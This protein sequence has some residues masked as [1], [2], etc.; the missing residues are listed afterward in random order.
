MQFRSDIQGLRALA[1]LLVFIFHLNKNWLPGGFLGVDLFFVI[2]GFLMTTITLNE[3]DLGK[4]SFLK[5]YEKRI[6]RILP[7][8]LGFLTI[9]SLVGGG[10]YIYTDIQGFR[11]SILKA[12]K[13]ISNNHFANGE[14]YFGAKLSENPVLH[15]WSLS[16][17][18]QFYFILPFILYF[19]RKYLVP[20]FI[21]SILGISIYSTYDIYFLENQQSSYFSL[22]SRIPEF[23]IGCLYAI[24]FKDGLDLSR[25][26]NDI[27]ASTSLLILLLCAIFYT[28][29]TPFP[30]ILALIPC[31]AGT[32][33]LVIKNNS[34]S[35][36]F[37]NKILVY[38]GELSYSLY[39]WHWGIMALHRYTK[40]DYHFK[41]GEILIICLLTFVM[42]WLS[43][44]LLEKGFR[45]INNIKFALCILSLFG[46]IYLFSA[47]MNDF[48]EYKKIP[49]LYTQ[50]VFG[51]KSHNQNYVE[52]YGDLSQKDSIILIGDSHAFVM[53][54]FLDKLGK[55]HHFS[56]KTLTCDAF[57]AIKG[58]KKE[59]V[60]L[61]K[62][63]FYDKSKSLIPITEKM[64]MNSKIIIINSFSFDR[65]PSMK[66]AL[67]NLAKN[68]RKDQK[69]I[70]I[71]TFPCLN[72]HPLKK[73]ETI[74]PWSKKIELIYNT[75]N[76]K[77]VKDI[78][79][80]YP[81]VY[82]YD[83]SKSKIFQTPGYVNDTVAY[84][85]S[86]HL[87]YYGSLKLAEDL[88]EDFAIFINNLRKK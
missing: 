85:D 82:L 2:S 7:A 10:L 3:I 30:G 70:L 69:L 56:F 9:I 47:K 51:L 35:D 55:K 87:N 20:I 45:K 72:K 81:N 63:H 68:L 39:L 27:L 12:I 11:I 21:I 34:I 48:L 23:L 80:K 1:F 31:V 65:L 78:S 18:M 13:F 5:F 54:P 14:S 24:L 44:H 37:S 59:E 79:G 61:D 53:K 67:E 83:L 42:A 16:I 43:Y 75:E 64:I 28:E 33:L 84:Y 26:K 73:Y 58:I 77:I 36:F 19:L 74:L 86:A 88:D 52:K 25:K 15:T 49:D 40:G 57:P 4:F 60:Y 22:I 6:K 29:E 38:I 62:M 8:Y 66:T 76:E 17:E 71:N 46:G 50:P 41:F 32:N